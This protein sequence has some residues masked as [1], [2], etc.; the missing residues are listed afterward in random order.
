MDGNDGLWVIGDGVMGLVLGL[1]LA[2]CV[3]EQQCCV[4]MLAVLLSRSSALVQRP[5]STN[6]LP[7]TAPA[8]RGH[9]KIQYSNG[10]TPWGG[11]EGIRD[12]SHFWITVTCVACTSC[13][14]VHYCITSL[15]L[16]DAI[17]QE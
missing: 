16:G 1:I 13:F 14:A 3:G 17:C 2:I 11:L 5:G 6:A 12:I 4:L 9:G 15:P 8:G 7:G 10:V